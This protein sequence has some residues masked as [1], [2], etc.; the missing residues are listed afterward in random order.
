MFK[1]FCFNPIIYIRIKSNCKGE[2]SKFRAIEHMLTRMRAVAKIL[3]AR[4]SEH[5]CNFCEQFEQRPNF[6]STFKLNGTIR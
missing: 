2:L 3:R 5:S 4:S 1:P 6:A